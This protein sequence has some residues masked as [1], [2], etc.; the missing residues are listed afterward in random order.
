MS[1][2]KI[3][4]NSNNITLFY[5]KNIC[6]FTLTLCGK[7]LWSV[8]SRIRTEQTSRIKNTAQK[9]LLMENSIFCVVA[10][11]NTDFS[12]D[13]SFDFRYVFRT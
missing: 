13:E 9:K 2:I 4:I 10:V 11:L 12:T 8:F 7:F 5:V 3:F 6:C 1:L